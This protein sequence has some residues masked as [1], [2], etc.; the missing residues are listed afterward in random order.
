[1]YK[2]HISGK[3]RLSKCKSGSD[4]LHVYIRKKFIIQFHKCKYVLM[5]TKASDLIYL[6]AKVSQP[7]KICVFSVWSMLKYSYNHILCS[8]TMRNDLPLI[9]FDHTLRSDVIM[10]SV[11]FF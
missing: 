4:C 10:T 3:S 2:N 11:F 1:M 8:C 5:T 6:N 7:F 9:G